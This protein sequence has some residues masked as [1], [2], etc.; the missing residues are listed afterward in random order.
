M[1]IYSDSAI[2]LGIRILIEEPINS[3]D[4][5]IKYE[6]I[7]DDWITEAIQVLPY[8]LGRSGVKIQSLHPF[9]TSYN[10]S[11]GQEMETGNIWLDNQY[12]KLDDLYHY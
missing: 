1:E 2:I 12:L 9:S 3:S 7:S 10:L 4:Y 11:T 8:Y 5:Y 6:F